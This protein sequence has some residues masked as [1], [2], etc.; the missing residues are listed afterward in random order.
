M[1]YAKSWLGYG[2]QEAVNRGF[3][4]IDMVDE[5]ATQ[6]KFMNVMETQKPELCFLGGHGSS[7]IF[8]GYEQ[9]VVMEACQ[10]DQVMS[11]TISHLLSC[12][13]GQELLPSMVS[14][15]A[16]STIGYNV[17]FQ[18]YIDTNYAVDEDPYAQPFK[19]LTL[20]IITK[21]LDGVKLKDVWDAGIAKCDELIARYWE[22]TEIDWANVISALRH[23]R[24]GM[25]AL[26]DK[27]SYIIPPTKV[28][29]ATPQ[30]LGL[31]IIIGGFILTR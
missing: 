15:G 16:I 8:T 20:T 23:D 29:L 13:V 3:D 12:Y 17:D 27:E 24:D 18:F 7:N 26:G 11:G 19:E 5:E 6:E 14:K 28:K 1:T 22:R 9:Q 31:G 4:V 25:I 10:N 2:V 21:I 30:I